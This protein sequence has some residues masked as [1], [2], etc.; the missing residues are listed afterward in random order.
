[1]SGRPE[2]LP[3]VILSISFASFLPT[4]GL[5]GRL[6]ARSPVSFQGQGE[7][8][9][10]A[11]L[12]VPAARLVSSAGGP[13]HRV[14][15]GGLGWA[16]R[17]CPALT[18][19]GKAHRL[20]SKDRHPAE[21]TPR[22]WAAL[23]AMGHPTY[24]PLGSL[25]GPTWYPERPASP[26]KPLR[27]RPRRSPPGTPADRAAGTEGG[28]HS[29]VPGRPLGQRPRAR[30]KPPWAGGLR[31][32]TATPGPHP[33]TESVWGCFFGGRSGGTGSQRARRPRAEVSQQPRAWEGTK[34]FG[35][36][37]RGSWLKHHSSGHGQAGGRA[38]PGRP[39]HSP[40]TETRRPHGC[41]P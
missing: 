12:R 4:L 37:C 10:S 40:G 31:V 25:P 18:P 1:M 30:G 8:R 16:A 41:A 21:A 14:S 38:W 24:W 26:C 35:S 15:D 33:Q 34:E 13:R 32:L 7:Q 28:T 2:A 23:P 27:T 9:L 29:R 3:W 17:G 11:S 22:A 39:H 5:E 19:R 20:S 6:G 36:R